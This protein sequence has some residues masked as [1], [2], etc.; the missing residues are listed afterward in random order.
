MW[1]LA[2][3]LMIGGGLL[4]ALVWIGVLKVGKSNMKLAIGGGIVLLLVGAYLSGYVPAIN[5]PFSAGV[6]SSGS[7]QPTTVLVDD[8][9][10]DSATLFL[11][12]YTGPWGLAN[13]KTEVTAAYTIMDDG[14]LVL[15]NNASSGFTTAVGSRIKLYPQGASYYGNPLDFTVD[16]TVSTKEVEV[17]DVAEV[18]DMVISI[19]DDNRDTLGNVSANASSNYNGGDFAASE[20][21]DFTLKI[22]ENAADENR[23][24]AAICAAWPSAQ[25]V[26]D[27]ISN[28]PGWSSV[29]IPKFVNDRAPTALDATGGNTTLGFKRCWSPSSDLQHGQQI[30]M[31]EFDIYEFPFQVEAG[32]SAPAQRWRR[33]EQAPAT[34]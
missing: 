23:D 19:L 22:K 31:N 17:Y 9:Q 29:S 33:G 16:K 15:N 32:A 12:A 13:T 25:E 7:S 26:D 1:D 24:L 28:K 3:I 34:D 14:S 10:G 30:R 27:V 5:N 11:D 20:T 2:T 8:N 4:A 21:K 18:T 6:S